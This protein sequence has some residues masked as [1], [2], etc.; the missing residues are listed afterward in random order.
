MPRASAGARRS[1]A[2]AGTRRAASAA[3]A[4]PTGTLIQNTAR[5]DSASVKKP[6][7][8]GPSSGPTSA[9]IVS[10]VVAASISWRD[11]PR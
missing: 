10:Q 2:D 4:T 9:G 1:P 11:T 3:P 8:G 7:S 6:P 5:H